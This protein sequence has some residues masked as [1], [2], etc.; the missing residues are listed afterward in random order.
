MAKE[1]ILSSSPH[2]FSKLTVKGKMYGVIFALLPCL[3]ASVYFF[4]VLA[5][6]VVLACVLSSVIAE[7]AFQLLM[8]RKVTIGDGSAILTGLL[9]GL[10]LPPSLPLWAC[11][12]GA[13]V[14][15][16]LGKQIFGGLGSNIFN[17]AL[18]GRAFLMASF[19]V[20][21]TRWAEPGTLDA[22]T[23]ATPLGLMKF[24]GITTSLAGLFWG[25]VAGSLG[26][27][28]AFCILM[29]GGYLLIRKIIDW[30]V[31]LSFLSALVIFGGSMNLASP[32]RYPGALFHL[33]SGGLLFGAIFM[34][35][36][37]VTTPVTKMG[38]WAF[39]IG[40]GMLVVVIR[41]WGGLPEGV[42]Y[43]ILLM[44]GLTPLINRYTR[45]RRFGARPQRE[46]RR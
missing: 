4:K 28:S 41:L 26:E 2:I 29:G 19:P 42:M 1:F 15:I 6:G 8:R 30:R 45:P 11:G 27:T 34:A 25:N 12:L 20:L 13:V 14:A 39:G 40:C 31:P 9:L 10:V 23:G 3:F 21:L 37:P 16:G 22:V 17:P 5:V 24:E 7:A 43:S 38:R 35:T 18:L 46:E 36:D 33:L 32:V 44:N